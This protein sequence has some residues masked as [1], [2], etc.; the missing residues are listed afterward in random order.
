MTKEKCIVEDLPDV[1]I[2]CIQE[3]WE[4]YWAAAMI[5]HLREKYSY[6]IHGE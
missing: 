1:D 4:R 5:D 6:F 2:L 3:V